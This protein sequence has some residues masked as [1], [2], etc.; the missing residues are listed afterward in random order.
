MPEESVVPCDNTDVNIGIAIKTRQ[1]TANKRS[2]IKRCAV[3]F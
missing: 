2:R 3:C 1:L